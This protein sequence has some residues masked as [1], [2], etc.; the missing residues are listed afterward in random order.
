MNFD[1][2]YGKVKF[3]SP[4]LLYGEN[5]E[6]SFPKNILK[7]NGWNL[8]C[9]ITVEKLFSYKS[10]LCPPGVIRPCPRAIYMYKIM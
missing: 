3:A 6:T 1:L 4:I 2:F 10:K 7:T 8:Q 9:M 5:I